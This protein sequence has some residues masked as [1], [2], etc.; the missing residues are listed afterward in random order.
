VSESNE[1]EIPGKA[2]P[3][4]PDQTANEQDDRVEHANRQR[5]ASDQ[6]A[7]RGLPKTGKHS[8]PRH[9]GGCPPRH[10]MNLCACDDG[11]AATVQDRVA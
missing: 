3:E 6:L 1:T 5:V 8:G 4:K 10:L 2:Q 11:R 9:T 7:E